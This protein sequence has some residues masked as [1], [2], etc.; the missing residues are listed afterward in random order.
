M[1]KTLENLAKSFAGESQARNRYTFYA[2]VAIKEGYEQIAGVFE[3]TANQEK[4]HAKRFF[5]HIQELKKDLK[6]DYSEIKV[7][8]GVPTV[9]GDT[10]SNLQAA[11]SGEHHEYTDLYPEFARIAK[12]EGLVKIAA[13][14][15]AISVAEKHH[16]ERYLK[17]LENLKA[18]KVFRKDKEVIWMCRECGYVHVGKTPPEKCPSCDH[19]KAFYQVKSENY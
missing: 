17:L 4:S 16:E 13:R 7:E 19:P 11:A 15:N 10:A 18:G 9:Y 8:A 2:S 3:E 12:E 14:F 5:E 6:D 1:K